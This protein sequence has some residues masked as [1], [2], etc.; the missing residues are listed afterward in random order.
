MS[1]EQLTK[2]LPLFDHYP[3][4]AGH[5]GGDTDMEAADKMER[6]GSAA[7]LRSNV[8]KLLAIHK[9]GLTADEAAEILGEILGSIRPRFSE[10]KKRKLLVDTGIRRPSSNGNNQ[11]VLKLAE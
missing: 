1:S 2:G 9:E 8:L 3:H 6:S 11:R 10:L 4:T 5:Y 7:T